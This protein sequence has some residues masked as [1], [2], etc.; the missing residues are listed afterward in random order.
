MAAPGT[1]AANSTRAGPLHASCWC[2]RPSVA[3]SPTHASLIVLRRGAETLINDAINDA[4]LHVHFVDLGTWITDLPVKWAR[5]PREYDLPD[6]DN[7]YDMF[8]IQSNENSPEF[9]I[10]FIDRNE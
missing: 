2:E 9:N 1:R 10:E 5:V 6:G 3:A 4:L 7:R 8:W